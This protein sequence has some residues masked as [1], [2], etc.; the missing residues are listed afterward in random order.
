VNTSLQILL[1]IA[2][3]IMA[4][5]LAATVAS[6]LGLPLVLGE[7]LAG[8]LLGPSLLNLWGLHWLAPAGAGAVPVSSILKILAD[9]GV[10]L[11][12]FMAGVETDLTMMRR[13][14]GP[15]F[16]AAAGGVIL[17]MAGGYIVSKSFGFSTAEAIFIGTILTATSVTITAQALM[18]LNQLR[19]KVGSTILGAAVIDDVLGLIVLSVVITLAPQ[20]AQKAD[21]SWGGLAMIMVR[22][23]LCLLT[24]GLLGPW[25]TRWALKQATRL[26]GHHTEAAVALAI[27]LLLAF[28]A[29]WLGGMAAITGAYLAGLFVAMT[30]NRAK[31]SQ[32][33]HPLLNSFFG[34][35]FFVSI[36]MEVNAW[37]MGSR[38]SFFLLLLAIAV[39]GKILGCGLGAY[40][41][42]FSGR[43]SLTVGLGMIPR[44]EVGLITASLGWTAG[45]VTRDVYVQVVALVL[46]TTLVTPALLRYSFPKTAARDPE[47]SS[48]HS[49]LPAIPAGAADLA[50]A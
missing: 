47:A 24:M 46:L 19:S 20:L 39:A 3:V 45:L 38:P 40:S 50:D 36:G 5:K 33:I 35:V 30:P 23:A 18:N 7:L 1:C 15:A 25:L 12:M 8:V 2:V 6:R 4:A 29:Q 41:N 44:G 31:V 42:G 37:Q 34:P 16:W 43:D 27:A 10:V 48:V 28:A 26:H 13:T 21:A 11:L 9:I 32:E 22:M 17:A 49:A 14:V